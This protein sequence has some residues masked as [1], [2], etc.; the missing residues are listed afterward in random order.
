MTSFWKIVVRADE[1]PEH[2]HYSYYLSCQWIYPPDRCPK[3]SVRDPYNTKFHPKYNLNRK[4]TSFCFLSNLNKV[5][6]TTFCISHGMCTANPNHNEAA[7]YKVSIVRKGL[8]WIGIWGWYHL[9]QS[10]PF[11]RPRGSI[12]VNS[13]RPSDTIRR[14]RSG[15]TLA[16]VMACCLTTTSHYLN[17]CWLIISKVKWH[18]SEVNFIRDTSSAIH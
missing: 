18:A 14:H 3:E 8:N 10:P 7:L 12:N 9:T 13:L 16:Q 5:N 17:Q 2:L 6:T 11:S 15:S 1:L 4:G